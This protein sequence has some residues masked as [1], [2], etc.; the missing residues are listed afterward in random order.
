MSVCKSCGITITWVTTSN[1]KSMPIDA[2]PSADG[3]FVKT[4]VEGEKKFVRRLR[5]SELEANTRPLYMSHFQTCP[6]AD[7]HRKQREATP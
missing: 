2:A 3:R 5:E 4:R 1:T 7:K 6:T